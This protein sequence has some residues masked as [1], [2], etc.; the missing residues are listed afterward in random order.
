MTPRTAIT[1]WFALPGIARFVTALAPFGLWWLE[2]HFWPAA[3]YEVLLLNGA[4]AGTTAGM[5][6]CSIWPGM[7][8][9]G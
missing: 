9:R 4:I 5:F 2:I 3:S 8:P 1:T 7:R 6:F